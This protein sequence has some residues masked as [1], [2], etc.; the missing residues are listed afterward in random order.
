[1]L[2][3]FCKMLNAMGD[4]DQGVETVLTEE[5][6]THLVNMVSDVWGEKAASFF[7]DGWTQREDGSVVVSYEGTLGDMFLQHLQH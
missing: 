5:A 7:E 3:N 4:C 1:M 2:T 6:F